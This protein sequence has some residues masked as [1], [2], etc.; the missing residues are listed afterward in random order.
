MYL[1][2]KTGLI[3][4]LHEKDLT[5]PIVHYSRPKPIEVAET[6]KV[7]KNE[8]FKPASSAP[9]SGGPKGGTKKPKPT[10]KGKKGMGMG[11]DMGGLGPPVKGKKKKA[12]AAAAAGAFGGGP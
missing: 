10:G 4:C 9:T 5:E 3:E 6:P 1:A 7:K 2:T 11:P 8:E 12:A